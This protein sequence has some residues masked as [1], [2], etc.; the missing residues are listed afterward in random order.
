MTEPPL[1]PLESADPPGLGRYRLAGRLGRGGMGVVYLG[2]DAD[3]GKAAVKVI[4]P[5]LAHDPRFRERFRREVG[6]AGR[7]Q[8][9]CTA[10]VLDA[11]LDR[12]PLYVVT[13]FVSGPTLERAVREGGPL[14]GSDLEGLAVGMATALSAIHA[15]GLV[16]RD[17]KP[18]NV[19]LSPLGPR[20]IDF[21]IARSVDGEGQVTRT[22]T[23]F[24][25]PAFLAP[26]LLDGGQI[27]PAADVFS[28]GCVV[29]YAATG[30][31]PFSGT[32]L[33]DV[34]Y[35]IGNAEPALDGLDGRLRALVEGALH[36]DPRRRPTVP[37]L[38]SHLFG[39]PG[40]VPEQA[41]HR[42]EDSWRRGH[43]PPVPPPSRPA[44]RRGRG[45]A[46][47]Y[48]TFA[49]AG[50]L[51]VLLVALLL[52]VPGSPLRIVG[53]G[54]E[55][56]P[57][58]AARLLGPDGFD[59]PKSGWRPD[60]GGR[61]EK[62]EWRQTTSAAF[63]TYWS[64]PAAYDPLPLLLAAE[65]RIAEGDPDGE[66][67]FLCFGNDAI[68]TAGTGGY[69]LLVSTKGNARVRKAVRNSYTDL[70][71][72]VVGRLGTARHR[73]EAVCSPAG[74]GTR[75][76]LW[77]DGRKAFDT[78]DAKAPWTGGRVGLTVNRNDPT[79]PNTVAFF[80]DWELSRFTP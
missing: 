70:A 47:L 33:H 37:Q 16:H 64:W 7:V 54:A 45:R 49:G 80:D 31:S 69:E 21:G 73:L 11:Q 5:E 56:P 3:G 52:L 78:V 42:V 60:R 18:A 46:V 25:T 55:G 12:P 27:T 22:G 62:G 48:G 38:L 59:D 29:A 39:E 2:V 75:L 23:V 77:V 57:E 8:R 40:V 26:E 28:W 50:V 53:G 20:V 76:A 15:A 61:Y 35:R 41:A 65:V 51:A 14:R 30:R 6:A 44:E 10:A 24:G 17:L 68:G 9:F 63:T 74:A 34:I 32:T 19:L 13:E 79:W 67:G 71:T 1:D 4:S 66:A 43:A 72:G 36:K 58:A